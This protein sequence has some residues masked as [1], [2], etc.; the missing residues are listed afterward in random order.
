[1]EYI[2][3]KKQEGCVFCSA[4]SAEPAQDEAY[5]IVHRG[6]HCG[7]IMNLFPYNNGHLMVVPYEHVASL[8]E[9]GTETLTELM[10]L[11][12]RCLVALREAMAPHGFNIGVNLGRAA[13]A[14]IEDHVHVHIVPRWQGDTNFMPVL[15]ETRVIPQTLEDTYS[16]LLAVIRKG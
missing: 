12:K 3:G 10:L 13:G 6:R 15:G 5:L 4:F 8:E 9:L 16:R 7:V 1:M 2:L 14:G 11:T